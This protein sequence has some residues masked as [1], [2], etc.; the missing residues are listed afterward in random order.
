MVIGPCGAGKSHLSLR[1][2]EATG[3][4][5]HHIDRLYWS[6]GWV[7]GTREDLAAKLSV[8][9]EQ[10][11]WIIDGNYTSSLEIRMARADT[12]VF[13]DFP[14]RIYFRRAL[15]RSTFGRWKR[16]PDMAEGCDEQ[17]DP[18]FLRYVW[19]FHRDVRGRVLAKLRDR[20]S[21]VSMVT[22][23]HPREAERFL[24]NIGARPKRSSA[25]QQP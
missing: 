21:H 3:L 17:L 25:D 20:P 19:N 15:L 22:L 4:P 13:L 16:R 11:R 8:V 24:A 10:S 6:P 5:L 1:L 23:R 2:A 7:E 9:V 12:I 18:E 14:R